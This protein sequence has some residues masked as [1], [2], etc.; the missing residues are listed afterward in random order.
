MEFISKHHVSKIEHCK[1]Q[2]YSYILIVI[3]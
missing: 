3:V 2:L 1:A